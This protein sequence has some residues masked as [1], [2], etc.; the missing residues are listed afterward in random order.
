MKIKILESLDIPEGIS[1]TFAKNNLVCRKDSNELSKNINMPKI[2]LEVKGNS[3]VFSVEKANKNELKK[4][5]SEMAHIKNMFQGLQGKFVYKLEACNVHFP[6]TLKLE[7]GHLLINNFLG[8]KISRK[9][10]ILPNVDLKI[11]GAKITLS[12][13]D[14]V[15]AG[16]T[17]ANIEQATRIRKRDRRIFQDGIFIVEKPGKAEASQ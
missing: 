1:C 4:I 8:E 11:Q 9:A 12:S 14:K 17:A 15:A 7:S 2:N 13:S 6:M 16:Q 10:E 3:L 5:R